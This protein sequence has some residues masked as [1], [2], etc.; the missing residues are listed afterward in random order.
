MSP[1]PRAD[2]LLSHIVLPLLLLTL[3]SALITLFDLDRHVAD[4]LY[5]WQGGTWALNNA[6]LTETVL[7][8]GARQVT[9]IMGML[10][11][12]GFIVSAAI[13]RW[14]Q[15]L[16]PIG[17]LL[18]AVAGGTAIVSSLKHSLGASCPWEFSRYGGSL[19]YRTVFEQLILR[20]G[21]GCFPAGHASAGYAWVAVYFLG[22]WRQSNWR[23]GALVVALLVG[24]AF[25]I[26]RQVCGAHFISHDVW[27]LAVCWFW[28]ASLY[29][30][31]FHR[32]A[33]AL[34]EPRHEFA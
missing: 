31:F 24:L 6:W 25:G 30:I 4:T 14:R 34:S 32:P 13:P 1:S 33:F 20:N 22:L 2:F 3:A 16:L 18:L 10:M 15:F 26:A 23:H 11:A 9:R 19:N 8:T 21:K 28:S 7:H 12:L 27:M 17:F 5:T 29:L